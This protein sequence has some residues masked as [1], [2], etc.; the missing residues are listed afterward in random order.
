LNKIPKITEIIKIEP[1]KI[2]CRW[3]TDEVRVIDFEARFEEYKLQNN[4]LLLNLQDF[5]KFEGVGVSDNGT[6]IWKNITHK[7]HDLAGKELDEPLE[8]DPLVLHK[9]SK[10]LSAYKLVEV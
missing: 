4:A 7:F 6:L 3:N 2:T 1:F 8:L 5:T 9:T 10:P